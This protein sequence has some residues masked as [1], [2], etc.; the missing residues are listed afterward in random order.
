MGET[1][2]VIFQIIVLLMNG[3]VLL[4]LIIA[5]LANTFN[6][7]EPK[8][9][10]LYYDGIIEAIPMYKY[11]K[12]YSALNCAFPPFNCLMVPFLPFYMLA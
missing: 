11:N 2:G 12:T 1:F 8:S 9:L 10:A 7:F 5:I 3:V 4:N 6:I